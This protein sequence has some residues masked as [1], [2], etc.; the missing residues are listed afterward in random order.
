MNKQ[1]ELEKILKRLNP[2]TANIPFEMA[3][4]G[5]YQQK[6]LKLKDDHHKP[7]LKLLLS[8]IGKSMVKVCQMTKSK[9][10]D[11]NKRLMRLE[12]I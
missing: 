11:I 8:K 2:Q 1:K 4:L 5:L 3:I 9:P 10:V 7:Q 12:T 6:V